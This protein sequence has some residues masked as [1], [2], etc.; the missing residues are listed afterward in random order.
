MNAYEVRLRTA[1]GERSITVEAETAAAAR[2]AVEATHDDEI[3][4]VR[5]LH[6]LSFSCRVRDGR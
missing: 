1:G 4:A 6:V 3:V 5:L 2:D